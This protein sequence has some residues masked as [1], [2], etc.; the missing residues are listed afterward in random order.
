M[1]VV[2]FIEADTLDDL[3]RKTFEKLKDRPFNVDASRGSTCE[4]FGV[5][6]KLKNPRARLSRTESRGKAFSAL[7]ELLWY[8]TGTK[9]LSFIK[10]FIS[11]YEEESDDGKTI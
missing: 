2:M 6:L 3:M 9:E 4:I 8:L 7:G 11:K 1:W 5:L 10:Y